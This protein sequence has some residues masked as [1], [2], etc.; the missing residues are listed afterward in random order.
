[1]QVENF[2]EVGLYP[3]VTLGMILHYPARLRKEIW[4]DNSEKC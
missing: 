3:E 4:T 2:L 1:M